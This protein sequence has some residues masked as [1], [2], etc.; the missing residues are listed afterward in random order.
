MPQEQNNNTK[1][2]QGDAFGLIYLVAKTHAT[3]ITPLIR[4]H[5]GCEA[6]N[7]YAFFALIMMALLS[8]N[9]WGSAMGVYLIV[10]FFAIVYRRIETLRLRL[11]GVVLH[12]RQ[13]GYPWLAMRFWFVKN[14]D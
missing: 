10:W 11:K 6:F 4:S 13:V 12:S 5:H 14:V 8:A 1:L 9:R 2:T 3:G 7:P